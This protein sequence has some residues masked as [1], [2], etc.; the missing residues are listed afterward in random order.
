[1]RFPIVLPVMFAVVS[2]YAEL[3]LNQVYT[4]VDTSRPISIVTPPDDSGRLFLVKQRG[5]I[6]IL[7]EDRSASKAD[8]WMDF[9]DREMEAH[10]FEEGLLGLVF[11][12][13]FKQNAKYYVYYS[14]QG[15]KR[16]VISEF[17]LKDGVVDL[18]SERIVMEVRQP[19][20]NHN[21]GNMA[22]GPDGYLYICFGDGGK[23]D[24]P[25]RL[26]QNLFVLNGKII[27][28][29]VNT[30]AGKLGYGIPKDNPF[31]EV[32]GV[33][34]EI[35]AY[36]LRNPWGIC[37]EPNNGA[38]WCADVGQDM[39][40]EINIIEKGGNYG[41]NYMEGKDLF[42]KRP[43][44]PPEGAEFVAPIHV[45]SHAD[46]LS[47]TGGVVYR[48]SKLPDLKG[49]YIY[50]DWRWGKIWALRYDHA[51]KKVISNDLIYKQE[52]I[53]GPF[54]PNAFCEDANNELLVLSW[55]GKLYELVEN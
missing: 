42:S 22:F 54:R 32:K 48:G 40:E 47:I 11:H 19:F 44:D 23:R 38:F 43:E 55:D 2:S 37:F 13:E 41:W 36:G 4:N 29:D 15:P 49:S 25:H 33:R 28:I 26:G 7:P 12:P 5:E 27:R 35:W 6:L 34:P 1:M 53:D 16:S 17:T 30:R 18:D 45:Y 14:Q 39:W 31:V 52:S 50:G 21:S 24:D 10:Q 3:S 51:G 9:S 20:W 8:V 46:G